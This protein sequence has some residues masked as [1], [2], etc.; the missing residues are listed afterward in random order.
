MELTTTTRIALS[1]EGA[2][3]ARWRIIQTKTG[4]PCYSLI[5]DT[6]QM[7]D[8]PA[9]LSLASFFEDWWRAR[10]RWIL[11]VQSPSLNEKTA[12]HPVDNSGLTLLGQQMVPKNKSPKPEVI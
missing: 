10:M 8:E 7:M 4:S 1:S 12:T 5:Y 2:E 11:L 3:G 9:R 6:S